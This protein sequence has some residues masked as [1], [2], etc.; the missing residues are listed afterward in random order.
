MIRQDTRHAGIHHSEIE[1]VLMR[2]HVN[3][4]AALFPARAQHV[5]HHL[6]CDCLRISRHTFIHDAVISRKHHN[7]RLLQAHHIAFLD[8]AQLHSKRF[9]LTQSAEGFGFVIKLVLQLV[10]QLHGSQA[11][12]N[13]YDLGQ[14][15]Q[16]RAHTAVFKNKR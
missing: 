13:R 16:G 15:N 8:Q 4:C 3:G 11:R 5:R 12:A 2:E 14:L 10:G 1:I 9:E 6:R 7:L